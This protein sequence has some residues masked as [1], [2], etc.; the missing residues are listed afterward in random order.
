[1]QKYNTKIKEIDNRKISCGL[2]F[3]N[4]MYMKEKWCARGK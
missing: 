1:M 4:E 2:F 3:M